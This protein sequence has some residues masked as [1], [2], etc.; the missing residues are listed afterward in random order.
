[1]IFNLHHFCFS[2][3]LGKPYVNLWKLQRYAETQ[4]DAK[5]GK[6]VV[7]RFAFGCF[8]VEYSTYFISNKF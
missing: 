3:A 1:M 5:H 6:R 2:F 4:Q 8:R 7:K